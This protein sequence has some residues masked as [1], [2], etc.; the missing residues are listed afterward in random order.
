MIAKGSSTMFRKLTLLPL[1]LLVL[2]ACGGAPAAQQPTV[3]PAAPTAAPAATSAPAPAA[4][5]AA[6]ACQAGFRSFDHELLATDPLCLPEAPERIIALDMASVELTLL[7]EKTLLATS[8]WILSELPLLAPQ[9]APTLETVED[10]GYPANLEQ[11]A[12]LKPDL[13]L[14]VGGT[15][16]GDTIDVEQAQQIAPVVLADPA[17]YNDW[18]LGMRLWS[19]VLNV[20]DT[21]AAMSANYQ[22]RVAELQAALGDGAQREVSVISTSTYGISL[23]MPDTPPGAILND[24]GLAR[25]ESQRLVGEAASAEYGMAQYVTISEERLDLADGDAIFFFSYASSDPETAAAEDAHLTAFVEKP[26]WQSLDA[27]KAEQAFLV[28]GYWW[29]SQTYILANRVIDDL[30]A[31]LTDSSAT[32]PIIEP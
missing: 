20:P 5:A 26:I 6:Q 15:S 1:A 29:R 19:D 3:A 7:S 24:V 13:I 27:V 31:N 28:P 4:E 25:P 17:I 10:V 32:T 23:W 16:A 2:A 30:F 18:K 22:Q 12:L 14:A 11:V 9:F 21:Y 8:G